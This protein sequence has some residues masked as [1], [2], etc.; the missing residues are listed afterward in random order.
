[1]RV[2]GLRKS[3]IALSILLGTLASGLLGGAGLLRWREVS[4]RAL[5]PS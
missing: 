1:M 4:P 2:P 3:A 5:A